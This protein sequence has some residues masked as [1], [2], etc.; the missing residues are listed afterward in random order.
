MWEVKYKW[1][2]LLRIRRGLRERPCEDKCWR[3]AATSQG[4]PRIARNHQKLGERHGTDFLSQPP[5]STNSAKTLI[6]TFWLPEGNPS[7]MFWVRKTTLE[8]FFQEPLSGLAI[9]QIVKQAEI[10]PIYRAF[11]FPLMF[12]PCNICLSLKHM[13]NALR[14]ALSSRKWMAGPWF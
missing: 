2:H 1:S 12:P 4:M 11:S 6:S 14:L 5:E 8:G 13:L 9:D 3:D 10:Y 7:A